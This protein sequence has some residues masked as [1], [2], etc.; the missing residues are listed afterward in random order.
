MCH[1][2]PSIKPQ[3]L[4]TL[5]YI[6]LCLVPCSFYAQCLLVLRPSEGGCI[7]VTFNELKP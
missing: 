1:N 4:L 6:C 5:N 7:S 2:E 3:P